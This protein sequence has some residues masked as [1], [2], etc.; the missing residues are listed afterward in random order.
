MHKIKRVKAV[1]MKIK[2]M[3][4]NQME[5]TVK[6]ELMLPNDSYQLSQLQVFQHLTMTNL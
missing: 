6:T 4:I 5:P 3:T 1:L 2:S